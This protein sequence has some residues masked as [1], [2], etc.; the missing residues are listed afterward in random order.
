MDF[1]DD[2]HQLEPVSEDTK[3]EQILKKF[4]TNTHVEFRFSDSRRRV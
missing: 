3:V 2:I 4:L 1:F